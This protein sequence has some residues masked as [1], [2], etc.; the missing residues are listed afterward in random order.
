MTHIF[1]QK[2][3]TWILRTQVFVSGAAVMTL[4][5]LGSRFLAPYFGST[6]F[7]WGSL[8]GVVLSALSLGYYYGGKVADKN[9]NFHTFSLL[10]F[11]AGAYVLLIALTSAT[12]FDFVLALRLGERYGPLIATLM[13]LAIPSFLLG[14]VSPYS[15]RLEAETYRTVG[16]AAGNLYSISTAGSI[17]GTF[18]TVFILIPQ[19]GVMKILFGVSIVLMSVSLL[20]LPNRMRAVVIV[21]IS[22]AVALAVSEP[23]QAGGVIYAKDTPYHR[24]IV[25]DDSLTGVR[26]LVLDNN[27][28]SAMD[29][30]NPDRIVYTYTGYF[31]LGFLFS[32]EIRNVLFIGGGGFSGPKRFLR[33]YDW[34]TVDVVEIDPD[35]I[36]VAKEYFGVKDEE[37]LN[38]Y[39]EDGRTYLVNSNKKYDLIVL[40][41]Y[42]RTHIPFHLLTLEFFGEIEKDLTPNGVVVSNIISSLTGRNADIF[43]AE[44]KTLSRVFPK[45]YVFPVSDAG[46]GFVQNIITVA[47][48]SDIFYSKANLLDTAGNASY[49]KISQISDYIEHY[50]ETKI[51]TSEVRILT[52][53]YAPVENLINPLTGQSFVREED[54]GSVIVEATEIPNLWGGIATITPQSIFVII[55]GIGIGIIILLADKYRHK[56]RAF[57]ATSDFSNPQQVK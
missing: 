12:L 52:D 33:D 20:R 10:I 51:E 57:S 16:R 45:V 24:L 15:I 46:S 34:I 49:L 43:K 25:K 54:Q 6:L 18:V 13:L 3:V 42:A 22:L 35:V 47:T 27:F 30:R 7:V 55:L 4:E 56:S 21:V 19:F 14:I 32:S 8:I 11:S 39:S 28:H 44:Y 40:D 23:V 36:Q 29:L 2:K 26:T 17:M 9:P 5:I 37:R 38:I 53:D 41:A 31:H 50:W 48:K 1:I